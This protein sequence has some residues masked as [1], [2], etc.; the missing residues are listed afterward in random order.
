M[1][2]STI[3]TTALVSLCATGILILPSFILN[4]VGLFLAKRRKDPVRV[5][6]TYWKLAFG[7]FT[8]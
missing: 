2:L 5:G 3:A 4:V 6:F 1:A 7:F 8:M